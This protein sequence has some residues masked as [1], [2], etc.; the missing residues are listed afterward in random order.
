MAVATAWR[1]GI[2]VGAHGRAVTSREAVPPAIIAF[3]GPLD[4]AVATPG[5]VR[6]AAVVGKLAGRAAKARWGPVQITVIAFFRVLGD[7]I[8]A[9]ARIPFAVICALAVHAI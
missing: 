4:G 6:V 1:V 7:A 8:P 2:D 3:F 5:I 9:A